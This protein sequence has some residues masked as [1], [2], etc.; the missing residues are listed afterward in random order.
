[1]VEVPRHLH[2]PDGVSKM[3]Y[4]QDE[5]AAALREGWLIDPNV[6]AAA[7][8]DPALEDEGD[9]ED[10]TDPAEGKRKPGRPRKV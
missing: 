9:V 6:R 2:K 5:L 7:I 8:P 1:M 10:G 4:T 3:V